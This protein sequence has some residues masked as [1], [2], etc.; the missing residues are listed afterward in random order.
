MFPSNP[1]S[2]EVP[3]P[4]LFNVL[5][6]HHMS[7][8]ALIEDAVE[9]GVSFLPALADRLLVLGDNLMDLYLGELSVSQV[10]GTVLSMLSDQQTLEYSS[11]STW[12]EGKTS[13]Q[14]VTLAY[15]QSKWVLRLSDDQ[16]RYIH[17]H[18]GRW[19]PA[20]SR[21]RAYALK[22]AVMTIVAAKIFKQDVLDVMLVNQMRMEYLGLSPIREISPNNGV[23]KLIML[24]VDAT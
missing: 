6:H 15:D 10:S 9:R 5:K 17:L 1:V 7:L 18:P 3:K 8:Q 20:S 23:G 21:V 11:F 2:E 16:E 14:V 22:T 19:S 24:L 13:Y 12:V 4:I